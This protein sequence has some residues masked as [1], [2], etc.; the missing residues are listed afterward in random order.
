MPGIGPGEVDDSRHVLPT[1]NTTCL[2]IK[3][4]DAGWMEISIANFHT[5]GMLPAPS[6]AGLDGDTSFGHFARGEA[7]P[8]S[9]DTP[10]VDI[11][12]CRRRSQI[13]SLTGRLFLQECEHQPGDLFELFIQREVA[14][15][16]QMN[17][18]IRH[19]ALVRLCTG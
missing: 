11:W 9:A 4:H 1:V 18:R 15:I 2:F 5:P 7:P 16:E 8:Q 14:G 17:F 3:L 10:R 19:I 12:D 13:V 6:A